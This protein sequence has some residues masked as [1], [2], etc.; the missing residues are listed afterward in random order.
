M[1]EQ[2][3]M[4]KVIDGATRGPVEKWFETRMDRALWLLENGY[5]SM[6]VLSFSDPESD[7]R[8]SVFDVDQVQ[9]PIDVFYLRRRNTADSGMTLN[10]QPD[11]RWPS[12]ER[13]ES[14]HGWVAPLNKIGHACNCDCHLN[15]NAP[16]SYNADLERVKSLTITR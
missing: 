12:P 7:A 10:C 4:A 16:W 2:Q 8:P 15:G 3:Y 9:S 11:P 14:C 1:A 13:H 6:R 5:S